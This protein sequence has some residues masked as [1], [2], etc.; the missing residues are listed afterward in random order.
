MIK[1]KTINDIVSGWNEYVRPEPGEIF[2]HYKG[3]LYE[4]VTT[5][6]IETTL[7][8]CI[9]YRSVSTHL[10]WVRPAKDFLEEIEHKGSKILRFTPV[11][12]T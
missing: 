7:E 2:K 10:I 4:I 6:F 8:P 9:V 3:E 12:S 5:G 11:K 1:H